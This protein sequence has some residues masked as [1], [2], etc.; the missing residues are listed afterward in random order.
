[1]FFY[2]FEK[3]FEILGS[4]RRLYGLKLFMPLNSKAYP[5]RS[6]KS[7]FNS[8]RPLLEQIFMF[9]TLFFTILVE[10]ADTDLT[11]HHPAQSVHYFKRYSIF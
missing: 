6:N 9:L 1:M 3:L 7:S 5:C 10:L 11:S 8:I 2:T 4:H